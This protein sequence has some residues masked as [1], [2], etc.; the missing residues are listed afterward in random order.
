MIA[1]KKLMETAERA[2]QCG[3]EAVLC[4]VVRLDG[5][6]YGRPGTRMLLTES[7]IRAGY[8]S[9]GCL[10]KDLSRQVWSATEDG[11][12]LLAFD[13]RS[14]TLKPSRYNTGCDGV[15]YVLCHRLSRGDADLCAL[16]QTLTRFTSTK[17][18]T[19]IRSDSPHVPIGTMTA[20]DAMDQVLNESFV[21]PLLRSHVAECQQTRSVVIADDS[22]HEVELFVEVIDPPSELIVFGA[23][24][25]V[26]PLVSSALALDW[27]VTVVGR[28]PEFARSERF[29]GAKVHCGD[30]AKLAEELPLNSRTITVLM[31]HDFDSDVAV[32]PTL[33]E[34]SVAFIGILGPKRRLARLVTELHNNGCTLSP[35]DLDRVRSP[36]GLDIGAIGP[37]EIALSILAELIA[38]ARNRSGGS[39]HQKQTPLHAAPTAPRDF[40]KA[41]SAATG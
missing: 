24:V 35:R 37:N 33:L 8:I 5:S 10:E 12:S 17:L 11:P 18:G 6:G 19:V 20:L 25:D 21:H 3:E 40:A 23:G 4:T 26:Q 22:G 7:G 14:S 16:K 27:R 15:V 34:S 13:T 29:P 39:L 31:T 41:H 30:L 28:R 1:N 2:L 38:F 36:V 32:L 9:G